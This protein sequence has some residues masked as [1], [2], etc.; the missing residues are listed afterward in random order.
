MPNIL[1][2]I[3]TGDSL[4]EAKK[5]L[6]AYAEGEEITIEARS[7]DREFLRL[8]AILDSV[9]GYLKRQN[10]YKSLG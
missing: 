5:R 3:C 9:L 8:Q 1:T 6:E 7:V 10:K 2:D 4:D